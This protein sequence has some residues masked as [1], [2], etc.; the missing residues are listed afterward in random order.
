[1]TSDLRGFSRLIRQN[2]DFRRLWI[3]HMISLIGDW[4]SYIAVSVISIQQGGGAF[5]V[6]MVLFVH[7]IPLALMSPI[8]G[9]LAD[10]FD[11]KWILILGYL[12]ASVLTVCMWGAARMESVWLLQTVLFF[13]VCVSGLAITARSAAI[14]ALVGREDLRLANALLG[15]TWSVMFTL[16]LALGGFASEY[17]SPSGAILLDAMTFVLAAAVAFKLPSLKPARG[18]GAPPRPGFSDMLQA[19]AYVRK[20]PRLLAMVLAKTP[21]TVANAGAWVTLNLVAGQRL[22]FTT[23]SIALGI[24]QSI[25]AI[26][27]GI[28]PLLPEWIIPRDPM[29]GTVVAFTG[30]LLLAG[31]EATWISCIGLGL[32]GIGQ[33]HNWVISSTNIQAATPDHLLGRV[34]SL[35]F[36]MFSI[37]GAFSAMLAGYLCDVF[38][39][40]AAGA[41]VTT[42]LGSGIWL[43][44][45]ALRRRAGPDVA[46]QVLD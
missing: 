31:F 13:R 4:L 21:P 26:G 8:S 33:G 19:W 20:R 17:L 16:G 27:S 14:P 2:R 23:L 9:P 42:A 1:M 29:V 3:S 32:W 44:C 37:G 24:F 7:S 10:R 30:I 18:E 6:G 36:L 34:I 46:S 22:S 45:I 39:D 35:D 28:G 38:E 25:R 12:G 40:P 43:F 41:W 5:A 11:R 15:L